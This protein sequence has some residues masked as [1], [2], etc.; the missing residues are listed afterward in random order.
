MQEIKQASQMLKQNGYALIPKF[1]S[2][3]ICQAAMD[4]INRLVDDFEP[5]PQQITIFDGDSGKSSHRLSKY[6]LDSASKVS[7]FFEAKAWKD[8]KLTVP[9]RQS[10]NKIGHSL[11]EHNKLFQDITYTHGVEE[12]CY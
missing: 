5:T 9:K 10:I 1:I 8:G 6:F 4:E 7:Y 11:H 2:P 3:E 12:L